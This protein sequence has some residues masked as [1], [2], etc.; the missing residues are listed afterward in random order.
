MSRVIFLHIPKTAGMALRA[1]FAKQVDPAAILPVPD[2]FRP[3]DVSYPVLSDTASMGYQMTL[4]D[5]DVEGYELIMGHYDWRLVERLSSD[6][7]VVTLL[8]H[9]VRQLLSLYN[10]YRAT[11]KADRAG[12]HAICLR[13]SFREWLDTEHCHLR[14]NQ[15]CQ[16]LSGQRHGVYVDYE[17]AAR[18]LERCA[19]VGIVED[20][21]V[22]V[23]VINAA[24]GWKVSKRLKRENAS[25]VRAED[26]KL[27]A[28]TY[29]LAAWNQRYDMALYDNVLR[30]T[31][32]PIPLPEASER[33]DNSVPSYVPEGE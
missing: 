29:S 18:N 11:P 28:D 19:A 30:Q 15:A 21:S 2:D 7:Q 23:D 25:P 20:L 27:D 16:V 9:P 4:T 12:S 6:W 22:S 14:L 1:A 24:F 32:P 8:R 17:K 26:V 31:P 3:T 33:G 10:F 13:L 5:A